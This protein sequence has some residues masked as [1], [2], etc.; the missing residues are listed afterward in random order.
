[1]LN[2]LK[3]MGVEKGW[4]ALNKINNYLRLVNTM[5]NP[6][7]IISNFERDLQTALINLSEQ[8]I[9]KLKRNVVRDVPK[10]MSGIWKGIRDKEG[11][12]WTEIF[13]EFKAEGG[14]TGWFDY[15]S[16]EEKT[17]DFETKIKNYEKTRDYLKVF[18]V[19]KQFVFDINETVENA[20][21]VA[22]Y[23]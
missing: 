19:T 17:K 7:F 11:N 1:M 22:A 20:V 13:N 8:N 6:E 4:K 18:K 15:K 3:N 10:A 5:L 2:G 9:K 23:K 12:N 14:K 16:L 21:R